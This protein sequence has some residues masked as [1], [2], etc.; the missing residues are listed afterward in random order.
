MGMKFR[1]IYESA[2][3]L[4]FEQERLKG[5]QGQMLEKTLIMLDFTKM[6][7][8]LD[9]GSDRDFSN[10]WKLFLLEKLHTCTFNN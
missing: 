1:V 5:K 7:F 9:S 6:L 4:V 2:T 10:R 3:W 8:W